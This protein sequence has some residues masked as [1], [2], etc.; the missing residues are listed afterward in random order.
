MDFSPCAKKLVQLAVAKVK[1]QSTDNLVIFWNV[2]NEILR[3]FLNKPKYK[4]NPAGFVCHKHGANCNS[5]DPSVCQTFSMQCFRIYTERRCFAAALALM[6]FN[7][8]GDDM[9]T[10]VKNEPV[11]SNWFNWWY[12]RRTYILKAFKQQG[13]LSS[14]LAEVDHAKMSSRAKTNM[15]NF[16]AAQMN[17]VSAIR[18]EI[19]IC[20]L[21]AGIKGKP[22]E[23]CQTM[24]KRI[25]TS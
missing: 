2:S 4:F 25:K 10:F 18:Q 23:K 16:E 7:T 14:N 15:S 1:E 8:A 22:R 20:F 12:E 3:E 5:L 19:Y 21:E 6:D 11:V 9:L 17:I 13:A 24:Q